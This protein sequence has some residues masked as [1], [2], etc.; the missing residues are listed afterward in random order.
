M[1]AEKFES[2]KRGVALIQMKMPYPETKGVKDA[3]SADAKNDFLL[4]TIR[5]ISS[6]K[7]MRQLP[8]IFPVFIKIGIQKNDRDFP[9]HRPFEDKE[10][11]SDPDLPPF[12]QY[13]DLGPLRNSVFRGV[14]E[15]LFFN[16]PAGRIDL[17][18]EITGPADKA[19]RHDWKIKISGRPD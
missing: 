13:S 8:V 1:T 17:L 16:L 7:I 3:D 12:N 15:I 14:P 6:I 11:A 4:E 19:Y 10:P 2:K 5:L 9:S 18:A